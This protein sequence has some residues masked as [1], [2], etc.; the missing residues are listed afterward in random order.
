MGN[1]VIKLT[2]SDLH[3]IIKESIK[4][5]LSEADYKTAFNAY[6]ASY[7]RKKDYYNPDDKIFEL[8]SK[9]FEVS[10][11]LKDRNSFSHSSHPS[12]SNSQA[13]KLS[14][15]LDSVALKL[16]KFFTRKRNQNDN[17]ESFYHDKVKEKF[18]GRLPH[19]VGRDISNKYKEF[20]LSGEDDWDTYR[21]NHLSPDEINFDKMTNY[22][23]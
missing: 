14:K 4:G 16:E 6:D 7:N 23:K 8:I 11:L 9:M 15:E 12:E 10:Q 20:E 3:G 17:L 18:N 22:E 1:K 13:F 5:I 2:E 21:N 19:E